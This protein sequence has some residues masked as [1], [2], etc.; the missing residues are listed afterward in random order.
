MK[1]CLMED[2]SN[3]STAVIQ[4]LEHKRTILYRNLNRQEVPV[5]R[6]TMKLNR[7]RFLQDCLKRMSPLFGTHTLRH[8][9]IHIEFE[10]EAGIDAGGLYREFF[11]ELSRRISDKQYNLFS[12]SESDGVTLLVNTLSIHNEKKGSYV[13]PPPAPKRCLVDSCALFHSSAEYCLKRS[14]LRSSTTVCMGRS[15]RRL[16]TTVS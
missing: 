1:S 14:A 7:E 16:Y 9:R 12:L 15:S 5:H 13:P 4:Q 2:N 11:M 6:V 8:F 3:P 10:G